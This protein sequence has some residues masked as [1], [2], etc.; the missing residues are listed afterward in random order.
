MQSFR[1]GPSST[2]AGVAARVA[3][4]L[5]GQGE[6]LGAGLAALLKSVAWQASQSCPA[7][8]CSAAAACNQSVRHK[9]SGC[10]MLHA[11][12]QTALGIMT[13]P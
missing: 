12:L 3:A 1:L 5:A 8:A 9:H 13:L 10:D 2:A 7:Q 11:Q 6:E 4:Q